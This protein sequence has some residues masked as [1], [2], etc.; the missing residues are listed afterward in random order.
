MA[1]AWH[2][3]CCRSHLLHRL[4]Q[5]VVF[6]SWGV[7]AGGK[8]QFYD[9]TSLEKCGLWPKGVRLGWLRAVIVIAAGNINVPI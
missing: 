6:S 8:L 2:R 7:G 5:Q 3:D 4:V 9:A 1:A